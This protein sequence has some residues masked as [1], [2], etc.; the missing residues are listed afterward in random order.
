M[1][2]SIY[3]AQDIITSR[4]KHITEVEKGLRC[5]CVCLKCGERL[6]GVKGEIRQ[7]HFRHDIDTECNGAPETA[8][9][10]L[11]KQIIVDNNFIWLT[12]ELSYSYSRAQKEAK[13]HEVQPDAL[14][15]SDMESWAIEVAVTHFTEPKKKAVYLQHRVNAVEIDLSKVPRDIEPKELEKIL[16]HNTSNKKVLF[17]A[18]IDSPKSVDIPQVVNKG[19]P[20]NESSWRSLLAYGIS[21]VL[22]IA[23]VTSKFSKKKASSSRSHPT[24]S[25]K[26]L[27][28]KRKY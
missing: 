25:R 23:G 24:H 4:I 10:E 16:I 11:A 21:A 7:W 26:K 28:K 12:P 5:N 2:Q 13:I 17:Q 3:L 19:E 9:H 18:S 14:L 22:F 6:Q 27:H 20:N 8:L 1:E 15:F